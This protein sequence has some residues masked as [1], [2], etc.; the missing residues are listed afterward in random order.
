MIYREKSKN[1]R[2]ISAPAEIFERNCIKGAVDDCWLWSAYIT[3]HGYGQTRI[4]GRGLN[5][6]MLAHRLSWLVNVGEIPEG[7]HVLHKCDNPPCCNPN[8][9]FLGTNLDNIKDRVSKN[10]SNRWIKDAPREKHPRTK[11]MGEQIKEML[12]LREEKTKVVDIAKQFNINKHHCSRLLT[13]A[14]KGELS[15]CT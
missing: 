4:G 1:G 15:W 2:Y 5:E 3:P 10:R 13:S 7:M 12:K 6:A 9:L 11:I 14:K 8:H